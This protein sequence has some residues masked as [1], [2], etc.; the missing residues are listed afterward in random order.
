MQHALLSSFRREH[1]TIRAMLQEGY[2]AI[3]YAPRVIAGWREGEV[4]TVWIVDDDA[5]FKWNWDNRFEACT[6]T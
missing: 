2:K 6:S 4:K 1:A 5:E 3:V